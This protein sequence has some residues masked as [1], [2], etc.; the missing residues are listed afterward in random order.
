VV[1]V[2]DSAVRAELLTGVEAPS[3]TRRR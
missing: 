2:R 1:G 3:L